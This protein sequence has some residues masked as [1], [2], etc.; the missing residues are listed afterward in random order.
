MSF[1]ASILA[2]ATGIMGLVFLIT[3]GF[4]PDL[5]LGEVFGISFTLSQVVALY[6]ATATFI[7]YA[8]AKDD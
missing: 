8:R 6:G 3:M 1:H 5:H 2:I 4:I 7:A